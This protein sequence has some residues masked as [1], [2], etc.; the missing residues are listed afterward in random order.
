MRSMPVA[1]CYRPRQTTSAALRPAGPGSV[2][3]NCAVV[4][5]Y[6]YPDGN[7][8]GILGS[9]TPDRVGQK[10]REQTDAY[11]GDATGRRVVSAFHVIEAVAQTWPQDD[12]SYLNRIPL[13]KLQPYLDAAEKYDFLVIIDVQIGWSTVEAEVRRLLPLLRNPRVHLALD[14]EFAMRKGVIPGREIGSLNADDINLTQQMLQ[15]LVDADGLPNK[16][17]IIHQFQEGMIKNKSDIA[18]YPSVDVVIDMDGFGPAAVKEAKYVT[19]IRDE[20]AEFG[21]IKLFYKQDTGLMTP[22]QVMRLR[23]QPDV[24]I[25]Q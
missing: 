17:L 15:E 19:F 16:M 23:P 21:G 14:P 3:Q 20:K 25:Y 18:D 12:G 7:A 2:F 5:Y 24:I 10:L 4:T 22:Q 1:D 6:G 9:D 13:A 8:L 11:Q